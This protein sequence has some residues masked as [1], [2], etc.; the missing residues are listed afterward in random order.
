MSYRRGR[1]LDKD[2]IFAEYFN[3]EQ[4]VRRNGGV[5]SNAVITNGCA[6]FDSDGYVQFERPLPPGTYSVRIKLKD[7]SSV[8]LIKYLF[9]PY[10]LGSVIIN[11]AIRQQNDGV[12]IEIAGAL[13]DENIYIDSVYHNCSLE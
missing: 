11:G 1:N 8:A 5:I 12:T 9:T 4:E 7:Y 10:S 2:L 3:S 6:S 13:A